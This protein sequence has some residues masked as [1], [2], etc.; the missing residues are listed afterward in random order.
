MSLTFESYIKSL[1][2]E[3]TTATLFNDYSGMIYKLSKKY[4]YKYNTTTKLWE[5]INDGNIIYDISNWLLEKQ[6]FYSDEINT[7]MINEK[8]F[9][10]REQLCNTLISMTKNTKQITKYKYLEN[11]FKYLKININDDKFIEEINH[12][13]T[14]LLPIKNGLVVDLRTKITSERN[15]EHYFSYE[16]PVEITK[17]KTTYFSDFIKSIM[18]DNKEHIS[19]LQKILG[20]CLSGNIDARCF[21]IWHGKGKNGKSMLLLLMKAILENQ[22]KQVMKQVF[23]AGKNSSNGVEALEIKDCRMAIL[24]ETNDKEALNES[25]IKNLT[26]GDP[27]T[28]RGLYKDPITFQPQSKIII[29]T[30]NKPNFNANDEANVDR[31][32][33]LPFKARFV[34]NPKPNSNERQVIL[35]IDKILIKDNLDEFFTWCLNGAVEYYKDP[36]F[37]PPTDIKMEEDEYVI[38]QASV[39]YW[40]TEKIEEAPKEEIKR[41][42]AYKNYENFCINEGINKENKKKFF[43]IVETFM[44]KPKKCNGEMVYKNFK[45]KDIDD[46]ENTTPSNYKKQTDESFDDDINEGYINPLDII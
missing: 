29:C 45:I 28:A 39:K 35:G 23:I 12:R 9:K 32:K 36:N 8:D 34:N 46:D 14:Y 19:Y 26:G 7:K 18:L 44:D 24:T 3:P 37:T 17:E 5:E 22:Y 27:M 42:E 2:T 38:E 13:Y 20:Y 11:V 33:F 21:F 16:C 25:F 41:S 15:Q 40:F 31:L 30:N 10:Q 43:E 6:K 1:E 4:L